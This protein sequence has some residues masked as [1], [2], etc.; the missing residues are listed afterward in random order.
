MEAEPGSGGVGGWRGGTNGRMDAE[1]VLEE[2]GQTGREAA[3]GWAAG[4]RKGRDH[5]NTARYGGYAHGQR[6]LT[7][8]G[9]M[10][11]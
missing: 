5:V 1:R 4:R 3:G 7:S 10:G 2:Q 9:V 6:G 11:Y 8:E